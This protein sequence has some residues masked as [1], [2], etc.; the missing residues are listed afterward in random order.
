[1]RILVMSDCH[2]SRRAVETVLSRHDDINN[3]FYLGDGVEDFLK[4]TEFFKNKNYYIVSG[5][6]DWNSMYSDYGEMVLDGVRVIYTHGHRYDVKYGAEKLYETAKNCKAQ[7]VLYGHTHIA[8]STYRDGVYLINPGALRAARDGK[9]G[10]AIVD[11]N[12]KGIVT[13]LMKL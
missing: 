2:G 3:V 9:E 4:A 10:Y 11:I 12:S 8:E 13:S 6:C 5:N 7:L 1:M